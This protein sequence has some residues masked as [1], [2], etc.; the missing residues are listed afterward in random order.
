M[1]RLNNLPHQSPSEVLES[2]EKDHDYSEESHQSTPKVQELAHDDLVP[3]E[4]LTDKVKFPQAVSHLAD[5][6]KPPMEHLREI[7]HQEAC[8]S[9]CQFT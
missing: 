8:P 4:S 1:V 9:N 3:E 2:G 7:V 5:F 6:D